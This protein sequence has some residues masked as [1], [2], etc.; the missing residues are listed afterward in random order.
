MAKKAPPLGELSKKSFA[1][2]VVSASSGFN[3]KRFCGRYHLIRH[4]LTRLT[5]YSQ[6]SVDQWAT[7]DAP[8]APARKQLREVERLLDALAGV[9][10]EEAVGPWLKEPNAAFDGSTPLQ[11]I[12]RG[13]G[14]RLWRM[15]YEVQ[16]GEPL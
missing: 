11:V 5:G 10:N 2:G 9:M 1:R 14:D 6:R 13:E 4:D 3:V 16:T 8:S 15:I 12:E 7:G